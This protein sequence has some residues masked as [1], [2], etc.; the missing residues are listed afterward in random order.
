MDQPS[1]APS[2]TKRHPLTADEILW[3]IEA[4]EKQVG[5]QMRGHAQYVARFALEQI[6]AV[7]RFEESSSK[8]TRCLI[9]LTRWLIIMTALL[10]FLTITLTYFT[11]I[12]AR[13]H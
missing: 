12:L 13:K 3:F 9:R 7:Q 4:A 11:I 8:L 5:S 1:G 10:V 2:L 6:W